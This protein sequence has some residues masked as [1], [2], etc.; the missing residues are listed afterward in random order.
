MIEQIE[1]TCF[2]LRYE[3]Y[4]MRS[5]VAEKK[6]M[7]SI[8]EQGIR[9]PLQGINISNGSRVLLD[10]F[11]RYRCAQ[12]LN[13]GIVP[14][15]S[16]GSDE[17][18]AI[19]KLLRIANAK[20][21]S[22]IEQARL[23]DELRNSHNMTVSEIAGLLERS[24]GWVS[25]RVG[26]IS[27]MGEVV[28]TKILRGDFPVYSYMYTLRSFMRMNSMKKK[29]I[30][31]FVKSVAGK[32][33]SVRDIEMLANGYFKG[34]DDIRQQIENGNIEWGLN[35]LK[36]TSQQ[37]IGCT[38]VEQRF[39]KDLEITQKYMQRVTNKSKYD[40]YKTASFYAQVN[41]LSG[42]IERRIPL[43]RKTIKELHDKSRQTRSDLSSS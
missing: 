13:I 20:S 18:F 25:M 3:G 1:I 31:T 22:I 30:E 28:M 8:L 21:L 43:F 23:I 42:G 34:G 6:M 38:D 40:G 17:P 11:K 32:R 39:L 2:D 15:H 33:L 14:Y 5:K 4:R 37:A 24:K 35:R 27:E 36:E 19:V 16:L 29:E 9:D 41:L 12:K 26:I 7:E 10:G